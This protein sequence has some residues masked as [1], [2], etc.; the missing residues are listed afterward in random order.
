MIAGVI[1]VLLLAVLFLGWLHF[2]RPSI[3]PTGQPTP[4][5]RRIEVEAKDKRVQLEQKTAV[6]LHNVESMTDAE[7][8]AFN[9]ADP[10]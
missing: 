5:E 9:N 3:V 4:A 2:R 8:T 7:L 10:D 1:A 6:D